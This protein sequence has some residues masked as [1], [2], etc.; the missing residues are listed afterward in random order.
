MGGWGACVAV[1]GASIRW[2]KGGWALLAQPPI[3][4][5]KPEPPSWGRGR[6]HGGKAPPLKKT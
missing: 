3:L 6:G 5:R 1:H 4:Y 2:E